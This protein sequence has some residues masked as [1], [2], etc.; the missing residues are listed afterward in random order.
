MV[1]LLVGVAG[2]VCDVDDD[3]LEV[4]KSSP[5]RLILLQNNVLM[6]E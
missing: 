4:S 3:D 1:E 2:P 5:R 6:E